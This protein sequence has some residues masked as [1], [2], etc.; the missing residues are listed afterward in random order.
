M[1]AE[2]RYL[3]YVRT[4]WVSEFGRRRTGGGWHY[5]YGYEGRP[6][7]GRGLQWEG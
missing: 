3:A 4:A 5:A 6:L 2:A 7:R 1:T